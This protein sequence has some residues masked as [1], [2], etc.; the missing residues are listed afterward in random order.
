M[1]SK[2][3]IT[4]RKGEQTSRETFDSSDTEEILNRL[5]QIKEE[6]DREF[7]A[8]LSIVFQNRPYLEVNINND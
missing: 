5:R 7:D 6:Y 1:E 4:V 3:T 8:S 2:T